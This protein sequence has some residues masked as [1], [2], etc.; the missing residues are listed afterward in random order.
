[1]WSSVV[2]K[3]NS[4]HRADVAQEAKRHQHGRSMMFALMYVLLSLSP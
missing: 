4:Y 3:A 2:L 1:M